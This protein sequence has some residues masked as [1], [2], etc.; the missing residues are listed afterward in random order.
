M[1]LGKVEGGAASDLV[2]FP[3]EDWLSASVEFVMCA[4]R[5]QGCRD[6]RLRTVYVLSQLK[7][8]LARDGVVMLRLSRPP[9]GRVPAE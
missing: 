8:S 5:S 4:D 9:S 6:C 2:D 3:L 7:A 1:A